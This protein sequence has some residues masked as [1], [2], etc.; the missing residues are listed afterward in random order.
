MA[1]FELASSRPAASLRALAPAP[2][3]TPATSEGDPVVVPVRLPKGVT[4][5]IV[6]RIVIT[7]EGE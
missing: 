5:E 3:A 4:R 1:A 2:A 6:L 7:H